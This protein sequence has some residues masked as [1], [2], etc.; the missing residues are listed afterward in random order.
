MNAFST[1]ERRRYDALRAAVT[2][3]IVEVSEL[4]HGYR[5]RLGDG[6]AVGDVGEWMALERRCCPFLEI[7]LRLEEGGAVWVDM[8]GRPGVKEI[9]QSEF[10]IFRVSGPRTS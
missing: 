5:S 8:T 1:E 9:L 7:G 3:A 6:V 10:E 2:K 4:A